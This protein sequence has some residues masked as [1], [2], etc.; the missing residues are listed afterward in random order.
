MERGHE[1]LT[2]LGVVGHALGK[3]GVDARGAD[4]LR[5]GRL[6]IDAQDL[7]VRDLVGVSIAFTV[8]REPHDEVATRVLSHEVKL[9]VVH[10]QLVEPVGVAFAGGHVR[11]A[12]GRVRLHIRPR[13][14]RPHRIE[15]TDT[16]DRP[17]FQ[18]VG[19]EV[20]IGVVDPVHLVVV[21][22]GEVSGVGV[23][24]FVDHSEFAGQPHIEGHDLGRKHLSAIGCHAGGI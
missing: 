4:D 2:S 11:R 1:H 8:D 15:F 12:V 10:V 20:V 3:V 22:E 19:L 18:G 5:L 7:V 23:D 13:Y 16:L 17:V 6:K 21:G 9:G 14:V 24:P